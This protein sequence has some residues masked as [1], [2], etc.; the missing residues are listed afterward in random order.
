MRQVLLREFFGAGEVGPR[1]TEPFLRRRL[2]VLGAGRGLFEH[3]PHPA[4]VLVHFFLRKRPVGDKCTHVLGQRRLLLLNS[5]IHSRLREGRL[6][7][8]VVP[9]SSVAHNIDHN[10]LFVL[11][12]IVSGK[13]ADKGQRLDIVSVHVEDGCINALREIARVRCTSCKPWVG[14]ESDLVVDDQMNRTTNA[15]RREVVHPK[16]LVDDTL[17]SEC[18]VTVQEDGHGGVVFLLVVGE[19]LEGASLANNQRVFGFEMGGVGY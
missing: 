8:L 13:L 15:V 14:G 10:V 9:V 18:C 4:P 6:I 1:A 5:F 11:C 19:E 12:A 7:R 16:G 2:V 17:T 3:A